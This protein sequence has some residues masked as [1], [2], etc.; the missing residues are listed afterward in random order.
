M[1]LAVLSVSP[2]HAETA[3]GLAYMQAESLVSAFRGVEVALTREYRARYEAWTTALGTN[4]NAQMQ[5]HADMAADKTILVSGGFLAPAL[6]DRVTLVPGGAGS[7]VVLVTGV[8]EHVAGIVQRLRPDS[9]YAAGGTV[10]IVV[11]R[12]ASMVVDPGQGVGKKNVANR[13]GPGSGIEWALND[14][15]IHGLGELAAGTLNPVAGETAVALQAALAVAGTVTAGLVTAPVLTVT[16]TLRETAGAAPLPEGW[17]ALTVGDLDFH[18]YSMN[19]KLDFKNITGK[20]TGL[21]NFVASENASFQGWTMSNGGKTGNLSMFGTKPVLNTPGGVAT[22]GN[23]NAKIGADVL[24]I[25]GATAKISGAA[26]VGDMKFARAAYYYENGVKKLWARG[27]CYYQTCPAGSSCAGSPADRCPNGQ[28][29]SGHCVC[30]T[31]SCNTSDGFQCTATCPAGVV[32]AGSCR[33]C[34]C[35]QVSCPSGW[36]CNA[37]CGSGC[38]QGHCVCPTTYCEYGCTQTCPNGQCMQGYCKSC[39]TTYCQ[40]GCTRY[41]PNGECMAGYCK[42]KP[43]PQPTP[44]PTPTS[45]R[46]LYVP[47]SEY[48]HFD[49]RSGNGSTEVNIAKWTLTIPTWA[50][51]MQTTLSG[52]P[53]YDPVAGNKVWRYSKITFSEPVKDVWKGKSIKIVHTNTPFYSPSPDQAGHRTSQRTV[54]AYDPDTGTWGRWDMLDCAVTVDENN[55]YLQYRAYSSGGAPVSGPYTSSGPYSGGALEVWVYP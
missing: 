44:T 11:P 15:R 41:C 7:A 52:G 39:P 35:I 26:A 54:A 30:P 23:L 50:R 10:S 2:V 43:Q 27:V 16:G 1:V 5:P 18:P 48:P 32:N 13:M 19:Q 20:I 12:P 51:T 45:Q 17:G 38:R 49:T 46:I 37:S 53:V 36:G 40:Y 42:L 47:E 25:G 24:T 28:C 8:P 29:K 22:T 6:A 21:G 33:A 31:V 3:S 55:G 34:Q 9:E 4:Q 14:G